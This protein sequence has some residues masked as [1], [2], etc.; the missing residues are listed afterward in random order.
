VKSVSFFKDNNGV[1]F[2]Y[3][4]ANLTDTEKFRY[5]LYIGIKVLEGM[6]ELRPPSFCE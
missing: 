2:E 5:D 6:E 3:D 4:W 1:V